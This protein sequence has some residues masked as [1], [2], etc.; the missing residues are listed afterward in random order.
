[1]VTVMADLVYSVVLE[2]DGEQ[3]LLQVET[4]AAARA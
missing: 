1:V 2:C 3:K 4:G